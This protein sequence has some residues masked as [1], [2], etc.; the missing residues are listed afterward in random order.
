MTSQLKLVEWNVNRC[1]VSGFRRQ[2][3]A[4]VEREPDILALV[5]VG[6]RAGPRA[7]EILGERGFEHVAFSQEFVGEEEASSS[8][9]LFASRHPF[10][11]MEGDGLTVPVADRAM[12]A[13][14]ETPFGEIEGHLVHVVPGSSNGWTKVEFFEAMYDQVAGSSERPQILCGDFNSPK[15]EEDDGTVEVFGHT[16]GERWVEAE[17]RVITG[18]EGEGLC[19]AYRTLHGYGRDAWSHKNVY[20]GE[21]KWRR[22]FDHV[23]PAPTL[24]PVEAR[25]LHELDEHSDH[26]P[27]EVVFEPAVHG[28]DAPTQEALL[29]HLA[30]EEDVRST[31]PDETGHRRGQFKAGWRAAVAGEEY[32]DSTLERLTWHNLGWRLGRLFGETDEPMIEELYEWCVKQQKGDTSAAEP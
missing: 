17:R 12:S 11:V 29:D 4:L 30:Y 16:R 13:V 32:A 21:V 26:T 7:G 1:S 19:D 9:V 18:L 27:L 25:Y 15:R 24:N 31:T 22:R 23:F 14:F 10:R 5:E 6:V 20:D 8:G 2:A 3:D 28:S